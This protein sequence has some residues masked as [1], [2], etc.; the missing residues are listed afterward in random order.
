MGYI[1]VEV[2]EI[3]PGLVVSNPAESMVGDV[4]MFLSRE[5]GEEGVVTIAEIDIMIAGTHDHIYIICTNLGAS[6][7]SSLTTVPTCS[8]LVP[9]PPRKKGG[10]PGNVVILIS[11]SMQERATNGLFV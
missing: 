9:S 2:V 1:C 4:N 6:L 10:Q 7:Y 8:R 3:R 11:T 5:D